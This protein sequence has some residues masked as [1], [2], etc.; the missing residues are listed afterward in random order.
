MKLGTQTGSLVNHLHSRATLGQPFPVVG[1]GATQL[2]WTDR[3][4]CTITNVQLVR[5][6]TIVSVQNDRATVTSGSTHDGSAEYS[7]SPK[8]NNG[9]SHYRCETDG[10]WQSVI[11][12]SSTG[13][14]SKAGTT[15]LRIGERDEYIDPSF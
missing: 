1:M 10:R 14:W 12:S 8:T 5:G 3:H 13:R 9:E 11:I 15:G 4:A 6:K 2:F 7:F